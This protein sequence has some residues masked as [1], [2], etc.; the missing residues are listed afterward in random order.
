MAQVLRTSM[1][2]CL[3]SMTDLPA[4]RVRNTPVFGEEPQIARIIVPAC[5]GMSR[6]CK[7]NVKIRVECG[8]LS[9]WLFRVK[10][11]RTSYPFH[12]LIVIH[13]HHLA[14]PHAHDGQHRQQLIHPDVHD[15]GLR[16][17]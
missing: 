1:E 12:I 4:W 5:A 6:E 15:A 10:R 9:A 11:R 8:E 7:E 14:S 16:L 2:N 3:R 17:G 13:A